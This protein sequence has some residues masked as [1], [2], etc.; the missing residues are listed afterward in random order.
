MSALSGPMLKL[1]G[2]LLAHASWIIA[3]LGPADNYVPQALCLKEGELQLKVFEAATQDEA[4]ASGH[5][6]MSTQASNYEACAFARDGL[7][8]RDGSATD[9]L[10]IE[11]ADAT[12][13]NV[14]TM[15]QPYRKNER[16]HFLGDEV[17][18]FPTGTAID[19]DDSAAL[20]RSVREGAQEHGGAGETWNRLDSS[21][22]PAPDLF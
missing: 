11:L 5:S 15:I 1:G 9:A 14:L 12:G 2:F 20:R 16:M 17:F 10:I 22:Q 21:R 6:F 18:L 3:D 4:V 13:A 19:Q 8:R 7:L